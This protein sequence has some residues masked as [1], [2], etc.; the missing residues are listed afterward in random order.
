V[1]EPADPL[2]VDIDLG[3]EPPDVGSSVERAFFV[4]EFRGATIVV[5]LSDP[6]PETVAAIA[7]AAATLAVGD[8][9]LVL[10]VGN[11]GDSA[12]V[13]GLQSALLADAVVLDAPTDPPSA[14]WLASLWLAVTDRRE[15]VVQV[16]EG[17]AA[18]AGARIAASLRA[19]K[20]VVTDELG[21]WGI[22][23]RSFADVVTHAGVYEDQ[24]RE[25]QGGAVVAAIDIALAAGVANVNLCR[26]ADLDR[27]LFT[28]DGAGTLFTSGGYVELADLRVDD[29]PAVERLVAQGVA[30]GILRPRSRAEVARLAVTGLG[31]RVVGSGHLA[32]VVSLE[33]E[34]YAADALGE[35]ACLA[36]VSRF[37]GAG[38]GGLLVDGLLDR[39]AASGLR[40]VFA[41][42]VSDAA[43]AFFTRKGF[44]DVPHDSVPDA[45][46]ADYDAARKS[47]AH[48]YWRDLDPEDLEPTA[49]IPAP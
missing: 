15:V 31:A 25:R 32:G 46:W 23:P 8:S 9:R 45:K 41:V 34:P 37:S 10:V 40:A 22:P 11:H 33:T 2:A 35:V 44:V 17:D 14:G 28:F 43:G 36:T 24:L 47:Q 21:G 18:V 27:E 48:V 30:D 19:F 16:P 3:A 39:G 20:L 13:A 1:A 42:T 6:A 29:L 49:G 38:A 12:A 26:P 5:T 4:D 7:R